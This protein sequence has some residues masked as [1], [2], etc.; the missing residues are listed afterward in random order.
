MGINPKI[1]SL[2][3]CQE[4]ANKFIFDCLYI[5]IIHFLIKVLISN[6]NHNL[7]SQRSI[8]NWTLFT[9]YYFSGQSFGPNS[10]HCTEHL[11]LNCSASI[12]IESLAFSIWHR[13]YFKSYASFRMLAASRNRKW[14]SRLRQT[15]NQSRP[16]HFSNDFHLFYFH[17]SI[18]FPTRRCPIF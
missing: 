10:S 4:S 1:W 16:I 7:M 9:T 8:S 18:L 5:F 14:S 17:S 3:I 11:L 13:P 12:P 6:F 2:F 15:P